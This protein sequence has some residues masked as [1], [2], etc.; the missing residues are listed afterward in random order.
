MGGW[1][2]G[3]VGSVLCDAGRGARGAGRCSVVRCGVEVMRCG[4]VWSEVVRLG[5]SVV[6]GGCGVVCSGVLPAGRIP[7]G[8]ALVGASLCCPLEVEAGPRSALP[9]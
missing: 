2:G 8:S 4:A 3:W 7:E 5:Y 1:E 9:P 6:L